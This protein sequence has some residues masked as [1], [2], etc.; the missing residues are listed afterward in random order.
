MKKYLNSNISNFS[1]RV[2]V[3]LFDTI[4]KKEKDLQIAIL[5]TSRSKTGKL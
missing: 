2:D 3:N 4:V 5:F 1:I